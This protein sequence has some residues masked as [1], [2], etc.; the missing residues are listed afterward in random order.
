MRAAKTIEEKVRIFDRDYESPADTEGAIGKDIPRARQW[1][2]QES[3][4]PSLLD[5]SLRER[6]E[7]AGR[8]GEASPDA[9]RPPWHFPWPH[10][11]PAADQPGW[12]GNLDDGPLKRMLQGP[13]DSKH[14]VTIKVQAAPGTHATTTTTGSGPATVRVER[15]MVPGQ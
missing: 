1:A 15:S 3:T 8:G 5:G 10:L 4:S 12:I 6:L 11:A 14:E 13:G 7:R 9:P 2:G